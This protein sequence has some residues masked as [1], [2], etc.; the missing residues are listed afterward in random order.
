MELHQFLDEHVRGQKKPLGKI[1]N[2]DLFEQIPE[3]RQ[4]IRV[5]EYAELKPGVLR[6][7]VR[8]I[9]FKFRGLTQFRVTA[10]IEPPLS[11]TPL[12]CHTKAIKLYSDRHLLIAQ[13]AGHKYVRLY[14]PEEEP[15]I[16]PNKDPFYPGTSTVREMLAHR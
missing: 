3:L 12:H 11:I 9:S 8:E 4:D 7:Y 1:S 2:L 5:P 13:V 15:R 14:R 6:E 16:Y 10:C